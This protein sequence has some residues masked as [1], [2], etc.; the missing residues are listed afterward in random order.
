MPGELIL[1]VDDEPNIVQ[2]ARMYLERIELVD[3]SGPQI[4]AVIELNPDIIRREK[5]ARRPSF[6]FGDAVQEEVLE[7]AG[8]CQARALVVTVSEQEAIPRIVHKARQMA[9]S[10]YIIARTQHI[11]NAQ[12]LLDFLRAIPQSQVA[13]ELKDQKSAGEMRPAGDGLAD[14]YRYVVMPMRI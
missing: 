14:Q 6:I 4:N 12:Y 3:R 13:F 1:V 7:Y 5:T 9:P 10:V 8:L 2:L 11:R